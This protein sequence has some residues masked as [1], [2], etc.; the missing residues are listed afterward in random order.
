[1]F[2]YDPILRIILLD[3]EKGLPNLRGYSPHDT[4]SSLSF[5]GDFYFDGF[6]KELPGNSLG[7]ARINKLQ[8]VEL[9]GSAWV[10][11]YL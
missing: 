11:L 1:M 8:L 4:K 5:R 10:L 2:L 6:C 9:P 7:K 3:K